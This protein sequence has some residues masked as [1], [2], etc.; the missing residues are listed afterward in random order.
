M[1]KI[2][3]KKKEKFKILNSK[4]D[5]L[6]PL[7]TIK[8]GYSITYDE[9]ENPITDITEVKQGQKV[10]TQILNGNFLSTIDQIEKDGGIDE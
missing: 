10:K 9:D 6:S 1:E 3:N 7:K 5:T 4:M 8:R 2:V